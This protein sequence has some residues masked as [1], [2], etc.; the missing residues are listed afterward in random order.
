[1]ERGCRRL[2]GAARAAIR[3]LLRRSPVYLRALR[4]V[5]GRRGSGAFPEENR[6]REWARCAQALVGL[7]VR[8][9]RF[10]EAVEIAQSIWRRFR[11]GSCQSVADAALLSGAGF[12]IASDRCAVPRRSGELYGF[13][14]GQDC[15]LQADFQS[16]SSGSSPH[17]Q[18]AD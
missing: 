8:L 4:G 1:M 18:K 5:E 2:P 9:D 3:R 11:W 6:W 13:S 14:G 17:E 16:A 10:G 7:L 15:I 12:T